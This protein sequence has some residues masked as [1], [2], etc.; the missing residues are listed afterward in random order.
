[1]PPH[2]RSRFLAGAL[3]LAAACSTD[4]GGP[5][6]EVVLEYDFNIEEFAT[7]TFG[8]SDYD[9]SQE[10]DIEF[11]A[12]QK[13]LPA[14][15]GNAQGF[16]HA[17]T[18]LSDDLF[19]FFA[20]EVSGFVPGRTYRFRFQL[21]HV[22]NY[23]SGCTVGTGASVYIKVGASLVRPETL[24]DGNRRVMNIDK[25]EQAQG[26]ATTQVLGDIRNGLLGCPATDPQYEVRSVGPA[27]GVVE[28]TAD[29]DGVIWFFFGTESAFETRHEIYF[30]RLLIGITEVN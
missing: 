2:T 9:V 25:G 22:T 28:L 23:H 12:T 10:A 16:F 19:M 5:S 29:D 4:L 11:E 6:E 3:L 7:W 24:V 26:S 18:N 1:M 27:A 17:G 15:V 13:A 8:A 21:H 30:V 20:N 14:S